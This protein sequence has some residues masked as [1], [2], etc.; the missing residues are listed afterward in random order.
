MK[1]I[2]TLTA[3]LILLTS[4]TAPH[5]SPTSFDQTQ[6]ESAPVSTELPQA[7]MPN[8]AS[9]YCVEQGYKSEIRTAADGSQ[10]GVCIFPDGSECDEWAYFRNECG[11]TQQVTE[12][13][14]VT[15]QISA[16]T[17]D[18]IIPQSVSMPAGVII[19]PRNSLINMTQGLIFYN[20]DGLTLGEL[21][22]PNASEVHSA[23]RYQS[24]L[25]FPLV[26]QSSELESR[27]HSISVNSGSTQTE[28]GGQVSILIP[29]DDK[30]MLAGLVGVPGE[31]IIFYTVFQP[32]DSI[33]RTQ[34]ILGNMDMLATAAPILKLESTES[35][36]WK[37]VAIQM[38]NGEPN[39]LWF[40]RVPWG[41]GGDI[42]FSYNE[43]LSYFDLASGTI[44]EVLNTDAMFSSLSTNQTWVAYSVRKDSSSEFF[45]R[46]LAGGN[47]VAI[48]SLPESDRGAGDGIFS[49]SNKYV[50]WREAQGSLFDGTFHQT[51]RVAALDGQIIGNFT[52]AAFYKTAEIGEG[53]QIK[54]VGWLNDES[55]LVQVVA[56][57]KP[58]DGV[59]VELNILTGQLRKFAEGFFAGWF[60]P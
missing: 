39:G 56:T 40:T 54:P 3:I 37:P 29:L 45:V 27:K 31:S 2:W 1:W 30:A 52:D 42:V 12:T 49:P 47:P 17:S 4:C 15:Q 23:G 50:A 38:K 44:Y 57:E 19:D 18:I 46:D 20:P 33:L 16:P 21:L 53:T 5:A 24:S 11:P 36:Y 35:R 51:I 55:I 34:F 59:V 25:N 43:G 8:P 13:P 41:I 10:S 28:P 7:N 48:P 58:H 32:V 26:F 60:Y 14:I 6:G 9:V 22:A